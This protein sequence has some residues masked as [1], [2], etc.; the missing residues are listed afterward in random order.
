MKKE[1]KKK[2]KKFYSIVDIYKEYFPT[3]FKKYKKDL[4]EKNKN[5]EWKNFE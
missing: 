3:L 2:E 1:P 5:M 4:K